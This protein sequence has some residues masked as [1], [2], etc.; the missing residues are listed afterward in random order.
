[1]GQ[2]AE[3]GEFLKAMRSR[4]TPEMVGLPSSGAARRVPGLRREEVAR[5]ADVS[6][7]YYTRL[8]QGRNIRPSRAVLG[9]VGRALNL[10]PGEQSHMIDLLENC[11]NSRPSNPAQTVRPALQQLLDAVGNVPALVLGRRTDVLAGNRLAFLLLAD[12]T[13]MPAAERNLTRWIHLEPRA[14]ELFGD[15]KT[16]A[17][18]AVG[19]LRAD[20]GRHPNDA[21][22]NQLVGE[23]AVQSEH[24][25]RWWAG[26]R[27][28][29]ASAGTVRLHHPVVGDLELNFEDLALRE[30]PD[31]VLRVFSA[32]PGSP[33]ADSL[34]LLGSY[35][36]GQSPAPEA[37]HVLEITKASD[38]QT[39]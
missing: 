18:E 34:A 4:I 1:M 17:S 20:I 22:A 39:H 28:A 35:G 19:G 13:A 14:R 8:E 31:Q 37:S 21:Q 3:F 2:S 36:A 10:D 30:D 16:V 12:F 11:A 29:A 25:R 26:H 7:D 32:K 24:F 27:V 23:L 5:L 15:W 6:T 33:S 38:T 9:S